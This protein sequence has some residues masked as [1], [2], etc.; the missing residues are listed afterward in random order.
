ML[1]VP[2]R[3][4]NGKANGAVSAEDAK[5]QSPPH[6]CTPVACELLGLSP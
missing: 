1:P 5:V 4:G 6:G 3:N 2:S